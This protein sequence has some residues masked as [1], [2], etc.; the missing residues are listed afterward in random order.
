MIKKILHLN[1]GIIYMDRDNNHY[2]L[3][4]RGQNTTE[5][6]GVLM[7]TLCRTFMETLSK[8]IFSFINRRSN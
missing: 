7:K 6:M 1:N 4:R 2:C 3:L 5:R 8:I